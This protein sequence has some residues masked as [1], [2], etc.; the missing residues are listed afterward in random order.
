M[1]S[2]TIDTRATRLLSTSIEILDVAGEILMNIDRLSIEESERFLRELDE[3]DIMFTPVPMKPS[4]TPKDVLIIK[5]ES[6]VEELK[7]LKTEVGCYNR[8]IKNR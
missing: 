1:A 7:Q 5:M 4:Q 2:Q 3:R 6:I 8:I